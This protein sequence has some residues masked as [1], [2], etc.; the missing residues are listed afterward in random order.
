MVSSYCLDI[1]VACCSYSL[2]VYALFSHK[3]STHQWFTYFLLGSI[4]TRIVLAY[5]NTLNLL[6][7]ILKIITYLYARYVLSLLFTVLLVPPP[8]R[9]Q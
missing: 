5:L 3:V 7:F 6:V 2:G 8:S 9:R 1:A 4:L